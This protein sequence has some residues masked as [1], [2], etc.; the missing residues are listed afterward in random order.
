MLPLHDET[1]REQFAVLQAIKDLK[2]YLKLQDDS[3]PTSQ[4]E[5]SFTM[6]LRPGMH[7]GHQPQ[8][9]HGCSYVP[10]QPHFDLWKDFELAKGLAC[11][12]EWERTTSFFSIE[13]IYHPRTQVS[14]QTGYLGWLLPTNKGPEVAKPTSVHLYTLTATIRPCFK[15]GYTDTHH[16]KAGPERIRTPNTKGQ[17]EIALD[18]RY[19][20]PGTGN[21]IRA[22]KAAWFCMQSIFAFAGPVKSTCWSPESVTFSKL[23]LQHS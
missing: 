20:A 16:W 8:T 3:L 5:Y 9:Q 4:D 18:H 19:D 21:H 11:F 6:T 14:P 7:D 15:S 22:L 12:R 23:W 13:I 17:A 1:L 2:Q 10:E